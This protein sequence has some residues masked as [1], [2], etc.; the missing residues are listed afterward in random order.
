M[1]SILQ[2]QQPRKKMNE[3]NIIDMFILIRVLLEYNTNLYFNYFQKHIKKNKK[4]QKRRKKRK[5]KIKI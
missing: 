1:S 2:R 4:G 3:E 5:L